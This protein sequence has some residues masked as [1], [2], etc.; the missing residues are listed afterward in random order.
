LAIFAA[1]RRASSLL[2]TR[3][4]DMMEEAN[5]LYHG[6]SCNQLRVGPIGLVF[7]RVLDAPDV[8]AGKF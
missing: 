8:T 3:T 6:N 1:I 4:M 7:D 2:N 5:H